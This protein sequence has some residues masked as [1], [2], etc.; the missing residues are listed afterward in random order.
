MQPP[1]H[2][3]FIFNCTCSMLD[4][5]LFVDMPPSLSLFKVGKCT[6]KVLGAKHRTPVHSI[7]IDQAA[8]FEAMSQ[9]FVELLTQ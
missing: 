8:E 5:Y 6:V 9:N 4:C 2:N 7:L 3:T 1:C